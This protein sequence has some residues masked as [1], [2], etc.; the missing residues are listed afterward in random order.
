ML[1]D[2]LIL[3]ADKLE[4]VLQSESFK[5]R[6]LDENTVIFTSKNENYIISFSDNKIMLLKYVGN[7]SDVNSIKEESQNIC[8]WFFDPDTSDLEDAKSIANDFAGVFSKPSKKSGK[9]FSGETEKSK[10]EN[11]S[12]PFFLNRLLTLF[13]ELKSKLAAEKNEYSKVRYVLFIKENFVPLFLGV[14]SESKV[15][16]DKLKK[17]ANVLNNFYMNGNMDVRSTITMVIL[18]AI[19]DSKLLEVVSNFLDNN[20]KEASMAARKYK[21]KKV[22]PE[23]LKKTFMSR[24]LAANKTLF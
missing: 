19:N 12:L 4:G 18:N 20:L 16:K 11:D 14:L 10:V 9:N 5:K 15:N 13:P 17:I 21:F 1:K 6:F 7:L 23:K 22:K 8:E 2:A 3:I 24:F